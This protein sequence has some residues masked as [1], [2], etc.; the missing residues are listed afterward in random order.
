VPG[1]LDEPV[2]VADL[3]SGWGRIGHVLALANPQAVYCALDLPESL[4]I[5]SAELPRRLPGRRVVGYDDTREVERFARAELLDGGG[6]LRFHGPQDLARFEPGSID[7]LLN[8]ASFQEMTRAQVSAYLELV[9]GA[10]RAVYLQ[11]RWRAPGIADAVG[12]WEEYDVPAGW[13]RRFLRD[14]AFSAD[15]FEAGFL[16]AQA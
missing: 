1:V 15:F 13:T 5:A 7:V 12:G 9:G 11:E 10:A 16:T 6:A 4:V 2:V 8:V 14:V 3:G